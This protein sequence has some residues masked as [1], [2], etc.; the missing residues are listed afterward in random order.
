M[1]KTVYSALEV[2]EEGTVIVDYSQF[3]KDIQEIIVPTDFT[4][5]RGKALND[6]IGL[7]SMLEF[8]GN[9][10]NNCI[11]TLTQEE[12]LALDE[13]FTSKTDNSYNY[14]GYLE[15]DVEIEILKSVDSY[16]AILL[17]QMHV[18]LDVRA[19]YTDAVAFLFDSED[20]LLESLSQLFSIA[21]ITTSYKG[22][23]ITFSFD[24]SGFDESMQI[25]I[26][27]DE[28]LPIHDNSTELYWFDFH[29]EADMKSN[30]LKLLSDG[31][32]CEID[33]SQFKIISVEK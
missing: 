1:E 33:E 23:E 4:G 7:I 14:N 5:G 26:Q 2:I 9:L 8:F 31:M 10:E 30:L 16:E 28:S 19:G 25:Y 21:Y 12:F 3:I 29:D 11:Q 32:N 22:D 18:G 20:G 6:N 24:A 27:C 13:R 15:R 17:V